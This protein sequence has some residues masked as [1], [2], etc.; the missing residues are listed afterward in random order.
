MNCPKCGGKLGVIDSRAAA[1]NSTR[2]RLECGKCGER[3]TS[4]E[5]I[6]RDGQYSVNAERDKCI[7]GIFSRLANSA[8]ESGYT[9]ALTGG[10]YAT[11]EHAVKDSIAELERIYNGQ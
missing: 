7:A 9:S 8:V 5:T 1:N 4:L 10:I 3:F 2:R 11:R 6:I